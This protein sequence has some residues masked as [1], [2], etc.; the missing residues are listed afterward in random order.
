MLGREHPALIKPI[1]L[2]ERGEVSKPQEQM[3]PALPKVLARMTE[4]PA[5]LPTPF[6]S[7]KQLA[8]WLT[9]PEHPLTA[10][11]FV[12]RVWQWH[13]GRGIV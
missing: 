6:G 13:F 4:T 1:Y 8:L 12:N 2:L 3:Q 7:R 5:L 9:Q 11:V 10:R